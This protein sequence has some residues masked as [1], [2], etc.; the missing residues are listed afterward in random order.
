MFFIYFCSPFFFGG[1]GGGVLKQVVAN[2]KNPLSP[3]SNEEPADFEATSQELMK[4]FSR[5]QSRPLFP[6]L[7]V[8][9]PLSAP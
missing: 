3:I 2:S 6:I 5:I 7:G 1:G 8:E 9:V 4:A